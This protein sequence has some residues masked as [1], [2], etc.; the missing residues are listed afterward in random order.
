MKAKN[1]DGYAA[2][3]QMHDDFLAKLGG[4]GNPVD[5]AT[6]HFAKDWFVTV[7]HCHSVQLRRM[8]SVRA[9]RRPERDQNY[10]GG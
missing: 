4:L 3:K 9:P 8:L 7:V 5:D 10:V 1:F 2:H 6:V